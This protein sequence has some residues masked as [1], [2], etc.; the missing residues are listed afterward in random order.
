MVDMMNTKKEATPPKE[1]II[2][3]VVVEDEFHILDEVFDK[4][5]EKVEKEIKQ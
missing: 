4:L 2:E 3:Y 1:P 5:F